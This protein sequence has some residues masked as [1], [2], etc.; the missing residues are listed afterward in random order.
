MVVALVEQVCRAPLVEHPRSMQREV[1]EPTEVER[2]HRVDLASE[3]TVE[4]P[5]W[6]QVELRTQGLVVV[7]RLG[8]LHVLAVWEDPVLLLFVTPPP[9]TGQLI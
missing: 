8:F 2:E 4:E 1:V 3:A 9:Q 7:V 5:R 6:Q